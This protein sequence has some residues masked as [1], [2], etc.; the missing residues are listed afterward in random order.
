MTKMNGAVRHCKA[1]MITVALGE[2]GRFSCKVAFNGPVAGTNPDIVKFLKEVTDILQRQLNE[3]G[4]NFPPV[5]LWPLGNIGTLERVKF[6]VVGDTV[7][8]AARIQDRSRDG[9]HTCILVSDALRAE[10][11]RAG[12]GYELVGDLAMKGK[13]EPVRVFEVVA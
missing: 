6:G 12:F 9:K 7:N 5:Y 10:T 4:G 2:N 11:E 13:A 1:A 3:Q 8:L